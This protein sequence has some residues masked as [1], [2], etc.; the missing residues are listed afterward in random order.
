M[1]ILRYVG[2]DSHECDWCDKEFNWDG[3]DVI[4]SFDEYSDGV[5]FVRW[6]V[7][8]PHCEETVTVTQF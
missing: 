1:S 4:E 8:C 7:V 6:Q 3:D 2:H 5:Q